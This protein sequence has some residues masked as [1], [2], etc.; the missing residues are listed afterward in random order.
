MLEQW[1][2]Q[3]DLDKDIELANLKSENKKLKI[4]MRECSDDQAKWKSNYEAAQTR[5]EKKEKNM[6][7]G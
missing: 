3:W 4:E 6:R 1:R 2:V 5:W 7:G